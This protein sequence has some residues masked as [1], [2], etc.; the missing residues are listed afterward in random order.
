MD[1]KMGGGNWGKQWKKNGQKNGKKWTGIGQNFV[2][3]QVLCPPH[4]PLISTYRDRP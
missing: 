3:R 4:T 2:F 1:N